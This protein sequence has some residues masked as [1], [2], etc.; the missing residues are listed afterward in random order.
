MIKLL[1]ET[2]GVQQSALLDALVP[3]PAT[4]VLPLLAMLVLMTAFFEEAAFRGYMQVQLEDR[5]RPAVA[6]F[7]T[8]LLFAAVH[9]PAPGQL[10]LFVF[11]SLGWGVLTYLSRTILPAIVMHGVVDGVMFLWVWK[12]PDAFRALLE[13]NVLLTGIS[14]LFVTW[15]TVAII[16]TASTIFALF[17]LAKAQRVLAHRQQ[18]G[19][20]AADRA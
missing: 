7:L 12:S 4:T 11:G 1:T 18:P 2:G 15:V 13:H 14:D 6:I 16:G 3:L 20:P 19:G 17:M 5:Y 9:F 8:A 10:P